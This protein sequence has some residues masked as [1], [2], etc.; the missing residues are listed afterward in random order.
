MDWSDYFGLASVPVIIALV[1]LLRWLK[2][3]TDYAPLV[4]VAAGVAWNLAVAPLVKTEFYPAALLGVIAGLAAAG[5]YDVLKGA[6][7]SLQ[8]TE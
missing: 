2:L 4:A 7:K 6:V 1:G 5:L 8:Q 3:P